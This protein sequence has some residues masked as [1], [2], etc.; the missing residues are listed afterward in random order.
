MERKLRDHAVSLAKLLREELEESGWDFTLE[1]ESL[2][3]LAPQL[4]YRGTVN[5]DGEDYD[6]TVGVF[7]TDGKLELDIPRA[8]REFAEA[9]YDFGRFPSPEIVEEGDMCQVVLYGGSADLDPE[10]DS[11]LDSHDEFVF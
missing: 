8:A 4:L 10:D 1:E 6:F 7:P 11:L 9:A 3:G 2:K 5:V